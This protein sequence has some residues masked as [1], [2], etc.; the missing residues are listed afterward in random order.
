M[1]SKPFYECCG[2]TEMV[3]PPPFGLFMFENFLTPEVCS[4]L[5]EFANQ[6][7]G[8]RLMVIDNDQ[9]TPNNVVRVADKRR[10][11]ERVNLGE[12]RSELIELVKS[13]FIDLTK[14]CTGRELEWFEAPDLMRY[15]E[16]GF[17]VKHADSQNMDPDTK[18][19]SKVIDRDLSMLIY[20]NDDFE[21]G[22][23]S[24]YK[25]NYRIRPRAG[26]AVLF[27]SDQRFLH[28]AEAV[29]KGV[30]YAIVSWASV[31][32]I[33]KIAEHAPDSAIMLDTP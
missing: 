22:E 3:R 27:P 21:G 19:W 30:R 13:T 26:A 5:V 28:Q 33:P 29:K 23:L 25:L 14:Q 10:I 12:R 9:S 4:D 24:F 18:I 2:S 15:H 20:L 31:R 32:G 11:T 16:G 8:E 7:D 17:Y 6:C 1:S